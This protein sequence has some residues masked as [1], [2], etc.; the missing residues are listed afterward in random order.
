MGAGVGMFLSLTLVG[1]TGTSASQP[2]RMDS[3]AWRF[4]RGSVIPATL[5]L[6]H[7]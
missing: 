5:A 3:L 7:S 2:K 1:D 4:G 6:T